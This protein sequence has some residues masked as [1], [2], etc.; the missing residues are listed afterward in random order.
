MMT[1]VDN[2]VLVA[3]ARSEFNGV[4]DIVNVFQFHKQSGGPQDDADVFDDIVLIMESIYT[5]VKAMQ[6][7]QTIY[8][9][10]TVRNKTQSTILGTSGWPTL[11]TGDYDGGNPPPGV[12][13]LL[14]FTSPYPRIGGRKYWG[15]L[16]Q[17]TLEGDG[18]LVVG[19]VTALNE[20]A[21]LMTGGFVKT[22]GTYV[23]GVTRTSDGSF[24]Y[25]WDWV[26]TDIPAYQRRR[27]QGRGS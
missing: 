12:S 18:T 10:I 13:A 11:L 8:R 6:T 17:S 14:S 9:D 20:I 22:T 23:Y 27:R 7:I 4:E 16:D 19:A 5:L 3:S 26:V 2:D 25:L 1:V 15:G 21:V 24:I